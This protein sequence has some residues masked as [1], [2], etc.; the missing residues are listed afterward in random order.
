VKFCPAQI[1]GVY[2]FTPTVGFGITVK[3]K[4]DEFTQTPLEPTIVAFPTAIEFENGGT[5]AKEV[6]GPAIVL[7]PMRLGVYN[8]YV[9]AP[10]DVSVMVFGEPLKA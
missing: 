1:T 10:L 5:E 3:L 2:E 4:L 8:V 9:F 7:E 6:V